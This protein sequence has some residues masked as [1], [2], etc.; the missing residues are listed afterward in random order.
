MNS[1]KRHPLLAWLVLAASL[2]ASP[3]AHADAV[4]DWN[5]RIDEIIVAGNVT[6]HPA[7][8]AYAGAH[9]AVY[10]AVNAITKRYPA[11]DLRLNPAPG[12]SVD[13]AVAAAS[14]V[15]LLKLLPAQQSAID[16]AY[17]AALKAVADGP[18]KSAGIELGERAAATVLA[19][20]GDDGASSVERYRPHTAAGTYVPTAIPLV[21][22]WPQR[23]PWLMA[24]PAQFRPG[25][26][27]ALTSATV[28]A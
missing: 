21:P 8:R 15:A 10:E 18:A 7:A 5:S 9:T 20:R 23:K 28:D 3:T 1:P 13:A 2:L 27:P 22:H 11:G 12:A 25:P 14:R 26:P 24:S 17:D 4:T 19:R 16:A 6:N